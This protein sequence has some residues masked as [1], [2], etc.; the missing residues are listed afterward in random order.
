MMD[1]ISSSIP[2]PINSLI[3]KFVNSGNVSIL[4]NSS[5]FDSTNCLNILKTFSTC[6]LSAE[7]FF[8]DVVAVIVVIDVAVAVVVD[9]VV[10][11]DGMVVV[12]M[13]DDD[14]KYLLLLS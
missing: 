11:V 9:V 2:E 6:F 4:F 10:I 8:D 5:F 14:V 3:K 12:D 13:N 1:L 7:S